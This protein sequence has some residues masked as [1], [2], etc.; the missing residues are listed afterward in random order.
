MK[1]IGFL[2][3]LVLVISGATLFLEGRIPFLSF[4]RQLKQIGSQNFGIQTA[5]QEIVLPAPLRG[6]VEQK[7]VTL[8]RLGVFFWT[9]EQRKDNGGLT[10][11]RSSLV[12]DAAATA[13]LSDMF[14]HQYFAHVSPA[15][16]GV[17]DWV[18]DQ[19]YEFITI[20]EN[21]ALGNYK[22]DQALVQAWMDSPGHRANILNTKYQEI[23][24]AAGKGMFEGRQTWL[25]VQI[26][27]LPLAACPVVDGALY[28][29]IQEQKTELEADAAALDAQYEELR[30]PTSRKDPEYPQKAQDYNAAAEA[31]NKAVAEVKT[32]VEQYNAQIK[33]QQACLAEFDA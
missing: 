1:T 26:F 30:K 21:L 14:E 8:S 2:F 13:K 5:P 12:L 4:E 6:S 7:T 33:E 22:D 20:G 27:G 17:G 3:V 15:G 31:Y 9:N 32:M 24:I 23:G 10:A 29:K 16:L 25:A 18:G 28:A 19:H 11:L